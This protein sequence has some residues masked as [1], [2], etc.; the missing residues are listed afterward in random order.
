[1]G[2]LTL[3]KK[4]DGDTESCNAWLR[5]QGC[6]TKTAPSKI[7]TVL[8]LFDAQTVSKACEQDIKRRKYVQ[9]A[10]AGRDRLKVCFQSIVRHIGSTCSFHATKT[11]ES[12]IEHSFQYKSCKI[13]STEQ[14]DGGTFQFQ[15]T[16]DRTQLTKGT[17]R[18]PHIVTF[19]SDMVP[20][21]PCKQ[22]GEL[23]LLCPHIFSPIREE[24]SITLPIHFTMLDPRWELKSKS[25]PVHLPPAFHT[26]CFRATIDGDPLQLPPVL[27]YDPAMAKKSAT[28]T[29][30]PDE[31]AL[32]DTLLAATTNDPTSC[33]ALLSA[34]SKQ[35]LNSLACEGSSFLT[36]AVKHVIIEHL[37]Q[38]AV[39]ITN[40]PRI[41]KKAPEQSLKYGMHSLPGVSQQRTVNASQEAGKKKKSKKG[42]H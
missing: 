41:E 9:H 7:D 40:D 20:T 6:N 24:E 12:H 25:V 10:D 2:Y 1:M 36:P 16:E 15:V 22:N 38:M 3:G 37:Q 28:A 35:V 33:Y 21:C 19:A 31:Q 11:I 13:S 8:S 26:A 34:C 27:G 17:P 18:E 39:N 30:A 5:R 23:G 29:A 42:M 14:E 4:G 32:L